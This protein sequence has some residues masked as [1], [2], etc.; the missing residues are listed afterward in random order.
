[1]TPILAILFDIGGVLVRT[2]SRAPRQ[3]LAERLGF[4]SY[5]ALD[6]IVWGG[7][8]GERAQRG[9]ISAAEQWRYACERVG[10]PVDKAAEFQ[11][12]FFGGDALDM[13]LVALIRSLHGKY[14]TGVISNAL[15]DVR[16][17]IHHWGIAAD[18]DHIVLSGE[19]G[20]MKPDAR[21]YHAALLGLGVAPEE[22]VFID[23]L[24]K[25]VE[26]AQAVGMKAVRF[27]ST[28]QTRLDL[29]AL[30]ANHASP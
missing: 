2:E 3:Q 21:I 16:Q 17:S 30:L 28:E 12:A 11:Q 25:N 5:K 29:A 15:D 23:D 22:A 8:R 18:F 6:E 14:K 9:E 1:M 26:G 7:E 13:E 24:P 19:L 27:Q 10:W 20:V 4:D